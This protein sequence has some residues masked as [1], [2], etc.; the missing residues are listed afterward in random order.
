MNDFHALRRQMQEKKKKTR[1]LML[2]WH[3]LSSVA[4]DIYPTWTFPR[5][6]DLCLTC[7]AKQL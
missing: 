4:C 1:Y 5:L 6:L 3:E 2:I 7:R